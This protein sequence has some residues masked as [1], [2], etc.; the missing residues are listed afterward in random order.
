MVSLSSLQHFQMCI[1]YS[2]IEFKSVQ[3]DLLLPS[4]L[5]YHESGLD[6][7]LFLLNI[8]ELSA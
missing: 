1:V 2:V 6:A 5:R 7:E 8:S 4:P 3:N